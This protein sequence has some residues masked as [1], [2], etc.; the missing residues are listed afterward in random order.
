MLRRFLPFLTALVLLT[1]HVVACAQSSQVMTFTYTG[2][3]F[4][5][6]TGDGSVTTSNNL[7][8]V[9]SANVTGS[10]IDT[11]TLGNDLI[12]WSISDGH[13]IITKK[14]INSY[15]KIF[16]VSGS[17]TANG[18]LITDWIIVGNNGQGVEITSTGHS[19]RLHS[20]DVSQSGTYHA[21]T[22]VQGTW[23][24]TLGTASSIDKSC[25][26]P[27]DNPGGCGV[28]EPINVG[29]GNVYDE[30]TDYETAGPNKLRFVRYYN[31]LARPN[32][33]PLP[34]GQKWHSNYDRYLIIPAGTV[35]IAVREDNRGLLYTQSTANWISDSDVGLRVNQSGT[36]WTLT[37]TDDTVETYS[38]VGSSNI[39]ILT[40]IRAR[41][42][43]TQT[44][45]YNN[46]SQLASVTDSYNR[47]LSFIYQNGLLQTVTTPDGTVLTYGYNSSGI[48]PGVSDRLTSV[49]YPT[50]PGTSQSYLYENAN[51]PFALTAIIDEKGNR[52]ASWNYDSYSRGLSSQFG[53]GANL[54]TV[55]YNDNNGSRTVTS[56][57][58][59]PEVY[60]FAIL[61]S[62][63]KVTEIDRVATATTAAA[64]TTFTYDGNGYLASESDWNGNLTNY[65]NDGLGRPTK[66]VEAV[67]SNTERATTISYFQN[68]HL[69][70]HIVAPQVTTDFTYDASGNLLT[71]KLTDTTTTTVPYRTNGQTRTWT[72]TWANSL[73]TSVQNPR[74]DVAAITSF[75]YDGSGT[76][77]KITNALGQTVQIT[78]HTPGGLPLTLK[79]ANGVITQLSY[80]AR[81]RLTGS[82]VN[83]AAG[84]LTTQYGYDAAGNLTVVML[85]DGSALANSYDIAHRLIGVT[86]LLRQTIAYTLD[87]AGNRTRTNVADS[88]GTVRRQHTSSFDALA[89]VVSDTGGAAQK[90]QYAY[91]DNSNPLTI[92]D[93]LSHVRSQGFDDLN[94][95]TQITDSAHGNTSASFDLLDRPQNVVDPNG[96]STTYIYD[97]FGD[98]I[99]KVSPDSGTT[100]YAYDS[101]GNLTQKMDATS[102]ITN[103]AYDALDRVKSVM[104]PAA[105]SENVT[106][107]YDAGGHGFGVGRLTTVTDA[108]GTLNR[109]YDERGNVVSETRVNG[110]TT[111]R[112]AY[113]YDAVS[114]I[115][116]T[117]YPSGLTVAYV[118]DVMGR[119][120]AVTVN[121]PGIAA[122]TVVSNI[123]YQPFGPVSSLLFGN[124]ITETRRYDGDYRLTQI[125]A[126]GSR[127]L[128]NLSYGYDAGD[129]VLSI[130]DAVTPG[131]SQSF[132][133]DTLN[134]LTSAT[135]SYGNL[136]YTYDGVGNRLAQNASGIVTTYAYAPN[137]NRL[138]AITSGGVTQ[139]VSYTAAGNISATGSNPNYALSYNQAGR[140]AAVASGS[141]KSGAQYAYDA[142]GQRVSKVR[143]VSRVLRQKSESIFM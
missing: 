121:G 16:G 82:V 130:T 67:G 135:G 77:I 79:D 117:T 99:E 103:Y 66:I 134:H 125:T 41:N 25:G 70:S 2:S 40:S 76:L 116:N 63:P 14:D 5:T 32:P 107:T 85:P 21:N 78:Q 51:L 112:A 124:G 49:S 22:P 129:N 46:G 91:D 113:G 137:S 54:T 75:S 72:Y 74:A 23:S 36:I 122:Q 56:A 43:Y 88:G 101:N 97:G 61:Q 58:G 92:T 17:V 8:I 39:A 96:G 98:V 33:F 86:D 141:K 42:G 120:T 87:A 115:A 13:T 119:V 143:N 18:L 131:N 62:I 38:I 80:D 133:Y 27:N 102:A 111:L 138:A 15:L 140:L 95:L 10:T 65:V 136:A 114:R 37:D 19:N 57:L 7:T 94:R 35:I 126:V 64:A 44:L 104:Y 123:G 45:N 83:T 26:N 20:N 84:N 28:G 128:Q 29:T 100:V 73:L 139:S 106:Y 59:Q 11:G 132:G 89:R 31:S 69:P 50:T 110:T 93:P 24:T 34:L 1:L 4:T 12:T 48:S 127:A 30:I 90:T 108:A 3:N 6:V 53:V 55:S 52:F 109:S 60:H 105:A 142:F 68:Y 47:T 71:K 81:L 118:R 9:F